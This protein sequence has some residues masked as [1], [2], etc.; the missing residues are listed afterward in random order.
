MN[1]PH[2]SNFPLR[3]LVFPLLVGVFAGAGCRT[4]VKRPKGAAGQYADAKDL[5]KRGDF[6]RALDFMEDTATAS[7]PNPYT[8]RAQ[9]LCTII[10][11]GRIKSSLE[12]ADAYGAGEKAAKNSHFKTQFQVLR[13]DAVAAGARAA[14]DLGQTVHELSKARSQPKEF[15]LEA[16]YPDVE[17]PA[18][19]SQLERVK[20][21]GWIEADAQDA[22]ALA[23]HRKGMDEALA[24]ALGGDRAKA[25]AALS[26]GSA[27]IPG[28]D[29]T[30]CLCRQLLDGA[31]A[32]D[33]KHYN[34]VQKFK[35]I[36]DEADQ[37]AG[38]A[39]GYLKQN[40]DKAKEKELQKLQDQIKTA[41]RSMNL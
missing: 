15:T 23:A 29:F 33:R 41:R 19:I 12:L 21:G 31:R 32:L 39:Q 1:P 13:Q 4:P 11:S 36:A 27:Q 40:P 9:V 14:L 28:L 8:E 20:E 17:G 7:P 10:Y 25:R 24:E 38:I 37:V 3:C 6:D 30:L 5:F 18:Q 2:F 34:D 35:L 16:P 22:A 26:A